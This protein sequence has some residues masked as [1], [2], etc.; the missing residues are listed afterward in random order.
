MEDRLKRYTESEFDNIRKDLRK[1]LRRFE[2]EITSELDIVRTR[3]G[4]DELRDKV[5][6]AVEERM[7]NHLVE[8]DEKLFDGETE[9]DRR[10]EEA[11][12]ELKQEISGLI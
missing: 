4:E 6:E 1:R 8:V 3:Y 2:N 9:I 5:E 12:Q 11:K 7:Q 10:M